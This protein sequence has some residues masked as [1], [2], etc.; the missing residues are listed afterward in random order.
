MLGRPGSHNNKPETGYLIKE[1]LC[2]S[3]PITLPL[4]TQDRINMLIPSH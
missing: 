3:K 1:M 2:W 4:G